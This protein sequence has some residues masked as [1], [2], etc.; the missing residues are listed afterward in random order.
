MTAFFTVHCGDKSEPPAEKREATGTDSVSTA[1]PLADVKTCAL[2]GKAISGRTTCR[3][4]LERGSELNTCCSFCAANIRKRIGR[5]P[6]SAVTV[7]YSTGQKIDFDKAVFVVESDEVPC[8]TPSVLAFV[9][10]A[11]AE[12]FVE[13]KNGRILSYP[14]LLKYAAEYSNEKK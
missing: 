2:C 11:E 4:K 3:I 13:S 5:Q 7:C 10:M 1:K 8:C 6:F 12:K 9:S 14:E